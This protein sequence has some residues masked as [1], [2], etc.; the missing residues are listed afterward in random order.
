VIIRSRWLVGLALGG[1]ALLA[2]SMGG[3]HLLGGDRPIPVE[4]LDPAHAE[5]E[6]LR[7]AVDACTADLAAEQARFEA[8]DQWVDSLR[9]IVLGYESDERTVAAEDFDV[10]LEAFDAYN[11]SVSAW[12][13]RAEDLQATWESCRALAERHNELVDSLSARSHVEP[14]PPGSVSSP[15]YPVGAPR[16]TKGV[17]SS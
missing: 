13:D 15:A 2:L 6:E 8:H 16:L 1:V 17:I 4:A 3:G 12:H 7:A 10:Y 9:A 5:V 14:S 11:E